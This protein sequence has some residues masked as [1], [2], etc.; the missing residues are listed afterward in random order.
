MAAGQAEAYAE[1]TEGKLV[2]EG[3]PR[4]LMRDIAAAVGLLY[5]GIQIM[6]PGESMTAHRH[7]ASA[8]RF[9]IEGTGA[10]TIVDGD[11][12]KVGPNDFAI[13]PNGTWH[14]HGVASD[15]TPCALSTNSM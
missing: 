9:V 10:W 4:D 5:T 3:V 13:T 14:E 2:A 1:T 8:L 15:G 7:A 6:N 12:L 11:R